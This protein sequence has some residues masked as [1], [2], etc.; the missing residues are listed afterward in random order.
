MPE[1]STPTPSPAPTLPDPGVVLG[2]RARCGR[3]CDSLDGFERLL[4]EEQSK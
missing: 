3:V 2:E 4:V 1:P